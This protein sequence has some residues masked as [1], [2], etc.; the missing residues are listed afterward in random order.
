MHNRMDS[1]NSLLKREISKVISQELKD[2]RLAKFI[3]IMEV[4]TSRNLQSSSVFV[5][6]MGDDS[7]KYKT[8]K[9]LNSANRFVQK[10]LQRRLSM[11]KIP[12]IKFLL[13][14][15]LDRAENLFKLMN[16]AQENAQ[17]KSPRIDAL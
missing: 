13:D 4:D 9:G 10:I 1:I 2:P 5:S 15:T 6:V 16:T 3:T 17:S 12:T 7:D 8:L 11:R 14:D